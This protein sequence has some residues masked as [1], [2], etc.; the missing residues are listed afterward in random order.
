MI[1]TRKL[2]S[3]IT[4]LHGIIN[5]HLISLISKP[6]TLNNA[7]EDVLN[8]SQKTT[9]ANAPVKLPCP[10]AVRPQSRAS[11]AAAPGTAVACPAAVPAWLHF[12]FAGVAAAA[13]GPCAADWD[14]LAC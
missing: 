6:V 12:A 7:D 4:K 13:A 11:V 8:M 1:I 9:L 14:E 3:A 2:K 5:H 10:A